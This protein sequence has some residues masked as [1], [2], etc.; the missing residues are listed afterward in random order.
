MN[1]EVIFLSFTTM[2]DTESYIYVGYATK[3]TALYLADTFYKDRLKIPFVKY[4]IKETDRR[5][6]TASFTSSEYFDVTKGKLIVVIS[7]KYH[8]NFVGIILNCEYDED[9]GVY[10][11]NCQDWSRTYISTSYSFSKNVTYY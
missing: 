9:N 4:Q 3:P 8:E 2:N 6:K 11:Y 1:G 7:S 10:T 5:I